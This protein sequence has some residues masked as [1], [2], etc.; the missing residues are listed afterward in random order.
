MVRIIFVITTLI[1]SFVV[2]AQDL[3][4]SLLWKISGNGLEKPSYLF[5]TMHAVCEINFDDD[6]KKA[7]EETSQIYLEIDMDDPKLQATMMKSMMMKDGVTLT[8]LMTEEDAVIVEAFLKE[9]VSV[10]L[11]M[12]DKFKPLMVN[13]MFIPKLL[14]CPMKTIETE[15]VKIAKEQKEEVYGLETIE[16]QMAAFDKIPNSIQ[17]EEIVKAAK[18][19]LASEKKEMK[20]M[21]AVY[22]SEDIEAMLSMMDES[23]STMFSD[24]SD[25]LLSNRNKNWIPIIEKVSK[26]KP[27]FYG[28]GAAHLAGESGVIKLLRKQGYTVEAVK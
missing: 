12:V 4:K 3:E 17:V 19:N 28:V 24:Y 16:D 2:K 8:S 6:I 9:N 11:K 27:T 7:L 25:I 22:E 15:L 18:N 23:E 26:E 20:K 21:L 10:S 1:L 13:S 14:G 5:G